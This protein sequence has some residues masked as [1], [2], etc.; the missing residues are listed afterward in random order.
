[1]RK[2]LRYLKGDVVF[3]VGRIGW[4]AYEFSSGE[5]LWLCCGRFAIVID[6]RFVDG[7]NMALKIM[8]LDNG[9]DV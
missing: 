4:G 6:A 9:S 2:Y 1:M 5:L 8:G 3:H 7:E